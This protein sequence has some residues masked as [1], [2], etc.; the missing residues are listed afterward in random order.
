[1]PIIKKTHTIIIDKPKVQL[2]IIILK[3]LNNIP[4]IPLAFGARF[5]LIYS[6]LPC[7]FA[8]RTFHLLLLI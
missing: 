6:L 4:V 2:S 7:V 8:F 5:R 3:S 1:M